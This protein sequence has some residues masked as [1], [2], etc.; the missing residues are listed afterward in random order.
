M[1]S[2]NSL[3]VSFKRSVTALV[4][5]LFGWTHL[6]AQTAGFLKISAVDGEGSF[7]D[8]QHKM[9]HPPIVRVV[10]ESNNV[11]QGAEVSFTLPMVGPSAVF[12][13]GGTKGTAI[14]DDKG[15]ARCPIYKP[16]SEEGRFNIKVTA[17]SKG[18][19]G[20]LVV[21]QSNTLAGGTSVGQKKSGKLWLVLLVGG[22]AAGGVFAATHHGGSSPATVP[23][24]TLSTGGIAVG[25]PR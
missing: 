2:S 13:A 6:F 21:S 18:K 19:T 24:T 1:L 17:E 25:A 16:N 10:D 23:P 3:S 5:I 14:T 12:V 9:S 11:V 22:A 20:T 8:I 15:I 4:L 7:N